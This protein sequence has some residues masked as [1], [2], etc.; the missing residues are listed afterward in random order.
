MTDSQNDAVNAQINGVDINKLIRWNKFERYLPFANQLAFLRLNIME[1]LYGGATRGGKGL[2]ALTQVI[3]PFGPRRFGDLEEGDVISTPFGTNTK[4]LRV[5]ERGEQDTYKF[6]FQ[7]G[8][9]VICDLEHLWK[10]KTS[11]GSYRK[12]NRNTPEEGSYVIWDTKRILEW[13]ENEKKMDYKLKKNLL[14]PLTDAVEFTKSY[15]KDMI[16]IEPY[17][18]GVLLGDGCITNEDWY[19]ISGIDLEVFEEVKKRTGWKLTI[20]ESAASIIGDV[21][22]LTENLKL[23][24][25]YGKYSY[26]KFIPKYYKLASIAIR[27]DLL[28]GLMDTDGYIDD[29]GHMSYTTTSKQL[30]E[31]VQWVVRSLGGRAS[32]TDKIPTYTYEEVK[33]EG[34]IAY[35]V[36]IQIKN[37]ENYIGI[38]RKKLRRGGQS[39]MGGITDPCLRLDSVEYM[40]KQPTRCITI[41]HPSGLFLVEDFIVTHNSISL[42]MAATQYVDIPTY[43]AIIFRKTYQELSKG[44]GLIPVSMNWFK[45]WEDDGVR[46]D[47]KLKQWEF[48]SGA[49]LGFGHLESER[50]KYNY[51][52]QSYQFIGFD[53]LTQQPEETYSF[54]FSRLVRNKEQEALGIPL[55]M[56][57]T[58]NPNG[59]HCV[60]FG[61][62]LT[63]EGWKDIKNIRAGEMVYSVDEYRTLKTSKVIGN[64]VADYDGEMKKFVYRGMHIECTPNHRI[65]SIDNIKSENSS[66]TIRH[67]DECP[68]QIGLLRSCNYDSEKELKEFVISPAHRKN[69]DNPE[70]INGDDFL[71]FL[72]WFLTEGSCIHRDKGIS[73][74]QSKPEGVDKIKNLLNR[75]G[76]KYSYNEKD[77]KLYYANLY[78]HFRQF[79]LCDE[80]FIPK[81]YKNLSRR[82]LQILFDAMIDG[83]GTRKNTIPV[84]YTSTSKQLCDDMGE[85]A[86][87]LGYSVLFRETAARNGGNIR[88]RL[89]NGNLRQYHVSFKKTKCG[90]TVI[91]TGNHVYDVNTSVKTKT[92]AQ[93][94]NY[95]GKIYC[96]TVENTESFIIRQNGAV[97]FSGNTEWVYNRFVNKRTRPA[98]RADI[99]DLAKKNNMPK[100][101]I[102]EEYIRYR[103][104]MFVPSLARDNPFLDRVSYTDSLNKLDPVTRAQLAEGNWEIR[105]M[106]NMFSRMWFE[107][108]PYAKVPYPDLKKVRYWD[109]AAT[110][111]GDATVGCHLGY[112]KKAGVFYILD[113][114]I[115][116]KSPREVER[117]IYNCAIEDGTDTSIYMEKEPGSAGIHSI[118]HYKRKVIPPGHRF[119]PDRVSGDKETRARPLSAA[120][121]K[122]LIKIAWSR[123]T[124]DWYST[125]MDQLETFPE[126]DHDDV[127]DGLSG[128]FNVLNQKLNH[129]ARYIGNVD[130]LMPTDAEVNA[131]SEFGNKGG[132]DIL[133]AIRVT[134]KNSKRF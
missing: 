17:V 85:I 66:I 29:R 60:P 131:H 42:L 43:N 58:T 129:T 70:V 33:K 106:G 14:I 126:A 13:F 78:E 38:S 30:A 75:I 51:I 93:H 46:W 112:D 128:A 45:K 116:H 34:R 24:G 109:M 62:V 123:R 67:L 80:K 121:E 64:T 36:W 89:I 79:G 61:E 5:Y 77:F 76:L 16:R 6:T 19:S 99:I 68:G 81:E 7:D 98:I 113:M 35:T 18:L 11:D 48:P 59:E 107:K 117:E 104:P 53:E 120:S 115:L 8:R 134:T 132:S 119:Y 65:C 97:W 21:C 44:D 101:L 87:K 2:T 102:T 26:E 73:I 23:Y 9:T 88:G 118:D 50:D 15:K 56:R 100:E 74:S 32:I 10:I 103:M 90:G 91:N 4:V 54:L 22:E 130:F 52:G 94:Y 49:I 127:V 27:T 25:L 105:A 72:G 63:T 84:K 28:K 125:A 82:Q 55:R 86:L 69:R 47:D 95:K 57:A 12:A 96:I 108:V 3:T 92:P 124:D 114:R 39:Y 40:G 31:D 20:N 111:D 1:A 37:G 41:E 122:E 83:D 133:N 110:V 71:E